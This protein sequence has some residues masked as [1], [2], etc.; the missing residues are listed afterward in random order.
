MTSKRRHF[1]WVLCNCGRGFKHMLRAAVILTILTPLTVCGVQR[2]VSTKQGPQG[3]GPGDYKR[4]LVVGG[5]KR[6]YEFHVPPS[7]DKSRPTP[8]VLN[9]H[10]GGG[11]P[12]NHR[13]LSRMNQTSD[14]GGFIVVYPQGTKSRKRL[15]P[16]YAWNAGTCCGWAQENGIDDVAFTAALLDDLVKVVH[17]DRARVYATGLSNGAMMCY[18]LAC[19]LPD[20]I[21]AIAP[22]SGPMQMPKCDPARPVAVM[23]FHGTRDEYAPFAGGKG[24]RSLP[25]QFFTSVDE[26]IRFWLK[27]HGL[28]KNKPKIVKKGKA[29]G[30][31]YILGKGNEK[32]VL[33]K[34]EGGGHTWPGGKFGLLKEGTLGQMNMDISASDLMWEFFQRHALPE[35]VG[36]EVPKSSTKLRQKGTPGCLPERDK[37][38]LSS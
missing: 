37:K 5:M 24:P 25:G 22:V 18:R 38:R 14:R 16:G 7:Y 15:W 4:K 6:Y 11:N 3:L 8:V 12:R 23:H 1:T 32:V 13:R 33:W 26:T 35:E 34:L 21:A 9:F 36:A 30:E 27:A 28:Q 2:G 20:R 10:G 19:E 31:Y 17:V 29:I